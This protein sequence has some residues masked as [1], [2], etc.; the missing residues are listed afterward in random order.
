MASSCPSKDI[1]I[2]IHS[3]ARGLRIEGS[4]APSFSC[5]VRPRDEVVRACR[6]SLSSLSLILITGK[7]VN[8]VSYAVRAYPS[9][10]D[11]LLFLLA[12]PNYTLSNI[13]DI[14]TLI[15]SKS[16]FDFSRFCSRAWTNS[17][18]PCSAPL[19]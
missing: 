1:F 19:E 14:I 5:L 7:L 9:A 8:V 12:S 17:P 2:C 15:T 3:T 4:R 16:H 13:I 11:I 10:L 6:F 18:R